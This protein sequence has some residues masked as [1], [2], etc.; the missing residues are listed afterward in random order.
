M[1]LDHLIKQIESG[2]RLNYGVGEGIYNI[3]RLYTDLIFIGGN[4]Q[5]NAGMNWIEGHVYNSR[6]NPLEPLCE[7]AGDFLLFN[8]KGHDDLFELISFDNE[9]QLRNYIGRNIGL[10]IAGWNVFTVP[11]VFGLSKTLS[12][13]YRN[14][15][16]QQQEQL[17]LKEIAR[18][19]F[20]SEDPDDKVRQIIEEKDIEDLVVILNE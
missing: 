18:I 19:L 12:L 20:E 4:E 15:Q 7:I 16:T 11:V 10:N 13:S 5:L 1:K 8:Y 3:E 17:D 2:I 9:D 14:N 6:A